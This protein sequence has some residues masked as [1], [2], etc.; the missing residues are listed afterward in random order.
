MGYDDK[1]L[2]ETQTTTT[3][4]LTSI[5]SNTYDQFGNL[6]IDANIIRG[7]FAELPHKLP[8]VLGSVKVNLLLADFGLASPQIDDPSRGR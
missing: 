8:A 1:T 6:T 3:Q 7:N 2:T 5:I 4:G